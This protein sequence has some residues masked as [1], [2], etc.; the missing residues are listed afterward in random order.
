MSHDYPGLRAWLR[1]GTGP[2]L[3]MD[4][5]PGLASNRNTTVREQAIIIGVGSR[6]ARVDYEHCS[7]CSAAVSSRSHGTC[8]VISAA[9][10]QAMS[11]S[12][13]VSSRTALRR[14]ITKRSCFPSRKCK[15]ERKSPA[16]PTRFKSRDRSS[17]LPWTV[18]HGLIGEV[19]P[20]IASTLRR[21]PGMY[22][23]K[24]SRSRLPAFFARRDRPRR[25][26]GGLRLA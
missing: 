5:L 26:S 20:E 17:G 14:R 7:S 2:G 24:R 10:V 12:S 6:S 16:T 3:K 23:A 21:R 22:G 25:D 15:T 4:G 11:R 1:H 9:F 8:R 19:S 13:L 18:Q